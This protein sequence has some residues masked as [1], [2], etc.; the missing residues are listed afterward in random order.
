[1]P[2]GMSSRTLHLV[3]TEGHADDALV[4]GRTA[5]SF[6][7][8]LDGLTRGLPV[9]PP[10]PEVTRLAT[11]TALD[12][13]RDELGWEASHAL[14]FSLHDALGLPRPAGATPRLLRALAAP[15]AV[16]F[17]R[18]LERADELLV[19]R[20]LFDD[21]ALGWLAAQAIERL[22]PEDLP[23]AVSIEGIFRYEPSQFAW[24]EA[25]ARRVSVTVRVPRGN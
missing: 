18:L 17:A 11:C 10:S 1:M 3:P 2:R 20:A 24:V 19:G 12:T 22:A 7:A 14:A 13:T 6:R 21:R 16:A 4:R 5:L 8:F 23:A 9:R 15:R 25:L